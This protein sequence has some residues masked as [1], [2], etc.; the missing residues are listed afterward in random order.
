MVKFASRYARPEVKGRVSTEPTLT[1]QQFK[2]ECDVNK[3]I[4]RLV[5]CGES[6]PMPSAEDFAD[7]S[8]I[9]DYQ[10]LLDKVSR[11]DE[12]FYALPS[13]LRAYFKNDPAEF[14]ATL[15]TKAGYQDFVRLCAARSGAPAPA[16]GRQSG[17]P[18]KKDEGEKPIKESKEK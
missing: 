2:D 16:E 1:Q 6:L 15:R 3:I 8:N 5:R 9:E 12:T 18:Q 7:V 17:D 13:D 14:A 4:D 11:V 10:K